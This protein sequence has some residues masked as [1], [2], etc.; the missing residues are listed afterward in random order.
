MV[1]F[2]PHLSKGGWGRGGSQLKGEAEASLVD[3]K[4]CFNGAVLIYW[5]LDFVSSNHCQIAHKFLQMPPLAAA[6]EILMLVV[7]CAIS[8]KGCLGLLCGS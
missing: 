8:G 7:G 6:L 1:N 3:C 2:R 4:S 5:V